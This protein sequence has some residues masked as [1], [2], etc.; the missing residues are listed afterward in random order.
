MGNTF[1]N[2]GI[3]SLT[4]GKGLQTMVEGAFCENQISSLG[5][6]NN[7]LA[8]R[9]AAFSSLIIEEGVTEI[10]VQR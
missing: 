1:Q 3:A 2:V 4:I 10:Q 6:P 8:I 9:G 5:I 7:A